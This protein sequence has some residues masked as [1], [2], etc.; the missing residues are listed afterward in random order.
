MILEVHTILPALGASVWTAIGTNPETGDEVTFG[1]DW[2]AMRNL[3]E[4]DGPI[5]VEVEDWQILST[6]PAAP[7]TTPKEN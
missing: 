6:T 1:G 2:R 7:D 4:M 3:G 5:M